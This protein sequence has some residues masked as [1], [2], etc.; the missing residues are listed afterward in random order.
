MAHLEIVFENNEKSIGTSSDFSQISVTTWYNFYILLLSLENS[1]IICTSN[2]INIC[3][4]V[5]L[6][7][8]KSV[9]KVFFDKRLKL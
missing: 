8:Q 9:I 5:I 4:F 7:I 3:Y 6:K 2:I 1:I